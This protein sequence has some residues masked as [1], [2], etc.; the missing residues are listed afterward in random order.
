MSTKTFTFRSS[1]LHVSTRKKASYT[2]ATRCY[3]FG[4]VQSTRL[5]RSMRSRSRLS[6]KQWQENA[7]CSHS[8]KSHASSASSQC[9]RRMCA[10][11]ESSSL[12]RCQA[13]WTFFV[14]RLPFRTISSLLSTQRTYVASGTSAS[15][16]PISPS[17]SPC[18][19]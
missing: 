3:R 18:S 19:K 17:R 14:T 10:T 13:W 5:W 9:G 11:V 15:T 16:V 2:S 7:I 1:A 12:T 6:V 8:W 4:S